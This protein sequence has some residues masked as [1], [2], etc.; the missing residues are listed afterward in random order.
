VT[1]RLG[2]AQWSAPA[3]FYR[4][5]RKYIP[6]RVSVHEGRAFLSTYENGQHVYD[7]SGEPMNVELLVSDDGLAWQ[8]A[9]P[10]HPVVSTGGGSETAFAFD[11]AGDLYA[12][13]RN[14]RGDETGWGSKICRARAGSL[15]EW[16]CKHDPKKYD[17]P[18]A[19]ADGD[20]IYL[21]GRR[22]LNESGNFQLEEN[23]P[24][25]LPKTADYLIDYSL[26]PKRCALWQ[27]DRSSLTVRY[28]ADV[29]GWGDTCFPSLI[30]DPADPRRRF[31]YN[32]SSP[33]DGPDLSWFQGQKGETRI[34]RTPLSF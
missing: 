24:W 33:L 13:I 2:A 23:E 15:G 29:P 30:E 25:S 16:E 9:D 34:Y 22:N 28:I 3:G 11:R 32:Y 10:A 6:W 19:F 4:P 7:F 20:T 5:E 1:E 27:L 21:L 26:H 31:L 12:V 18:L 8:P 14:E 17:S